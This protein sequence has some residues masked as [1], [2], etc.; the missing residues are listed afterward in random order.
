MLR[1]TPLGTVEFITTPCSQA[2]WIKMLNMKDLL[3]ADCC[4]SFL[5]Q[6]SI[7]ETDEATSDEFSEC[8]LLVSCML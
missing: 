4:I 8:I 7:T 6:D 1:G 5:R 2:M 3:I